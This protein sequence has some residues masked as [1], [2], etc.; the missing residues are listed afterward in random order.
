MSSTG[1]TIGRLGS[2]VTGATPPPEAR[3]RA[4]IAV[5][6]TIGVALAGASEPV[7]HIVRDVVA[8]EGSE[9]CGIFGKPA[10]ASAAGAALANG[11]AAHALDF[12]DMCFVSLAH[13]SAPLVAGDRSPRRS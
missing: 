8:M 10:R 1:T 4:A 3:A 7:S 12:D 2:F 6:D 5:L 11:T 13:P 9:A